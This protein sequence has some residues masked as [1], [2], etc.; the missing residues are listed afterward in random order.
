MIPCRTKDGVD[1]IISQWKPCDGYLLMWSGQMLDCNRISTLCKGANSS[2][3]EEVNILEDWGKSLLVLSHKILMAI[4]IQ[5]EKESRTVMLSA[6]SVQH[7]TTSWSNNS[8]LD[9]CKEKPKTSALGFRPL[10]NRVC[11][12]SNTQVAYTQK[13]GASSVL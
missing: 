9:G 7:S 10:R 3:R 12:Y 6:E 11:K 4:G 5:R 2:E 13:E 1:Q 8:S